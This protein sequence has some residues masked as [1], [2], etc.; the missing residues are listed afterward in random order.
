MI[1][2]KKVA[3]KPK[4]LVSLFLVPI[5]AVPSCCPLEI[6]RRENMVECMFGR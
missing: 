2:A 1:E 4:Q 5:Y 3:V 6:R